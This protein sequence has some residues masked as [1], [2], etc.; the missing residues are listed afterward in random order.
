MRTCKICGED[1]PLEEFTYLVKQGRG[2][3]AHRCKLCR[4]DDAYRRDPARSDRMRNRA[5][6]ELMKQWRPA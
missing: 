1:K 5:F 4:A 2:Y 3:H 6:N